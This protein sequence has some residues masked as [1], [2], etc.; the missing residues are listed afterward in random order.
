[1]W[2]V[3]T[4]FPYKVE[5]KDDANEHGCFSFCNLLS[6]SNGRKHY[7]GNLCLFNPTKSSSLLFCFVKKVVHWLLFCCPERLDQVTLLRAD[8][9]KAVRHGLLMSGLVSRQL[10]DYQSSFLSVL[11]LFRVVNDAQHQ[12]ILA[13]EQQNAVLSNAMLELQ[14]ENRRLRLRAPGVRR[15]NARVNLN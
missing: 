5:V 4:N 1:M 12:R 14:Q 6:R 3:A 9:K 13:L 10:F 8:A 11:Q 7:P 15:K 2:K